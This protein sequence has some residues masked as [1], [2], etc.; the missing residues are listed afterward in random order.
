M[1]MTYEKIER[2]QAFSRE[3]SEAFRNSDFDFGKSTLR[4]KRLIQLN[5]MI[6]E[7]LIEL[8]NK[9][10]NDAFAGE[11]V[12]EEVDDLLVEVRDSCKANSRPD[13]HKIKEG[14]DFKGEGC[15]KWLCSS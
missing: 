9:A 4:N 8:N 14:T 6:M 1:E 5:N 2:H 10:M 13:K 3:K 7:K 11:E 12:V 15:N